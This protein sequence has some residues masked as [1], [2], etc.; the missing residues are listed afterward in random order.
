MLS[1][2]ESALQRLGQAVTRLEETG[3][4]RLEAMVAAGR[5][6]AH[7]ERLGAELL[8]VRADYEELQLT[9]HKASGRVDAAIGRLRAV[10][11]A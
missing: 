6:E 2:I 5:D 4:G 3:I 11:E 7:V 1:R 10:L 9:S 8:A